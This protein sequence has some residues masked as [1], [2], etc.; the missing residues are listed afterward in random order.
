MKYTCYKGYYIVMAFMIYTHI[1]YCEGIEISELMIN[2]TCGI[3][4][5]TINNHTI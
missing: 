4:Q 3:D 2:K 1:Y 5:V